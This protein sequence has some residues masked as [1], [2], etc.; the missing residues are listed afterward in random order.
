V[1]PMPMLYAAVFTSI[2]CFSFHPDFLS[3]IHRDKLRIYAPHERPQG[4][5][6]DTICGV[7]WRRASCRMILGYFSQPCD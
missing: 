3:Q 4:P 6:Y 7:S 5:L 1:V 2:L